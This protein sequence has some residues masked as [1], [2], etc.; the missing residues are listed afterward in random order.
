MKAAAKAAGIGVVNG[1]FRGIPSENSVLSAARQIPAMF[2]SSVEANG[3]DLSVLNGEKIEAVR[4]CSELDDWE[5][6]GGG[7]KAVGEMPRVVFGDAPPTMQEAMDATSDLREAL[8]MAC[9]STPSV[10]GWDLSWLSTPLNTKIIDRVTSDDTPTA[11]KTA[12]T[13][14]TLLSENPAAQTVVASIACDPNVWTAV[15]QNEALVEFLQSNAT[16]EYSEPSTDFQFNSSTSSQSSD[17]GE[18]LKKS[19]RNIKTKVVDM[20]TNLSDYFNNLFAVPM[21]EKSLKSGKKD[22]DDIAAVDI[23]KLMGLVVMVIAII[24]FKRG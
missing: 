19:L 14:F 15:L 13:A 5:F 18:V 4:P 20:V 17:Y 24:F 6:T 3:G 8:D 2:S 1:G 22:G 16:V 23:A 10:P 7:V 12:L 21:E 11:P 9:L